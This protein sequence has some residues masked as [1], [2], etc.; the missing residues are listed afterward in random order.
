MAQE[1]NRTE[2]EKFDGIVRTLEEKDL[3]EVKTILETW[4]RDGDV[5]ATNEVDGDMNYMQE[6]LDG[7]NGRTNFVAQTE[8]GKIIGV[9]GYSP[10]KKEL[11][12]FAKTPKPG[13]LVNAYVHK[14]YRLGKGVGTALMA[15]VENL[16]QSKDCTEVILESGPRFR[17]SGHPFYDR[18]G[19]ERAGMLPDYYGPGAHSTVFRKP[20]I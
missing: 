9:M 5:I 19:Y 20:L 16:A 17:S 18:M 4:L 6:S 11:L 13:E 10:T 3:P 1:E 12:P 15:T 2:Q 8:D 14:E 7:S